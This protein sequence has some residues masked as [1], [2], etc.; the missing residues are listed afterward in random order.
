[1]IFYSAKLQN[2]IDFDDVFLVFLILINAF[3]GIH[4][5]YLTTHNFIQPPPTLVFFGF[6]FQNNILKINRLKFF[7]TLSQHLSNYNSTKTISI[8]TETNIRILL[9][10]KNH[11]I[12]SW[13]NRST[14]ITFSSKQPINQND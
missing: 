10:K 1:M 5:P 11:R 4:P 9:N 6:F 7:N 12:I 3:S 8:T 14:S 13:N 2:F